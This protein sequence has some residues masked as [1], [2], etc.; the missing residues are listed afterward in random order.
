[1]A[2][3]AGATGAFVPGALGSSTPLRSGQAALVDSN[4]QRHARVRILRERVA[5]VPPR[6][7]QVIRTESSAPSS[8]SS[9]ASRT[10]GIES[11]S[12]VGVTRESGNNVDA[13]SMQACVFEGEF[14]G[15]E[16]SFSVADGQAL[17]IPDRFI[18]DAFREW[19]VPVLG[20][21]R[22]TSTQ[23][24]P[25]QPKQPH[26]NH[27]Y[28]Y[29]KISRMLPTVGCEADAVVPDVSLSATPV[30]P[31]SHNS[32]TLLKSV[33]SLLADA[34]DPA[35]AA[36]AILLP[37]G[38]FSS[39]SLSYN[40]FARLTFGLTFP[41]HNTA[42]VVVE[43]RDS[44]QTTSSKKTLANNDT[45][46][47]GDGGANSVVREGRRILVELPCGFKKA[48]SVSVTVEEY[49][50]EFC[51][52]AVLCGCGGRVASFAGDSVDD[53]VHDGNGD[54]VGEWRVVEGSECGD[55]LSIDGMGAAEEERIRVFPK[56]VRVRAVDSKNA[57]ALEVAVVQG[58]VM[59]VVERV[60]RRDDE[61]GGILAGAK[62]YQKQLS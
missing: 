27:D 6:G 42:D 46:G 15:H 5:V 22:I 35:R 9:K 14:V 62:C 54:E 59:T 43:G 16:V 47:G 37:S 55:G 26:Q 53:G 4:P 3:S 23:L 1:M 12:G 32:S 48:G 60:Y 45:S 41:S 57:A 30:L 36:A 38:C 61:G 10:T 29:L 52:G 24:Q 39:G 8:T 58:G 31:F 17:S 50:G 56:G 18:P 20:F 11:E 19:N 40:R 25:P 28:L 44:S 34:P 33:H 7:R 21:D 51:D 2:C 49:D 13:T